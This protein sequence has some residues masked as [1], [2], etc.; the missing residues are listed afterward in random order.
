M[1]TK[2]EVMEN[3]QLADEY[4]PAMFPELKKLSFVVTGGA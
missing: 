3:L 4:I 1:N 2:Q